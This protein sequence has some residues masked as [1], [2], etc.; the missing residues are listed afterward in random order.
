MEEPLPIE[1]QRNKPIAQQTPKEQAVKE[2]RIR[3]IVQVKDSSPTGTSSIERVIQ[4]IESQDGKQQAAKVMMRNKNIL[5]RSITHLYRLKCNG[6]EQL[7]ELPSKLDLNFNR[8][9]EELKIDELRTERDQ[10]DKAQHRPKRTGAVE[11]G[12]QIIGQTLMEE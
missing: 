8:K 3:D 7:N 10:G 9:G 5:Q 11:A 4:M 1:S 12:N 6:Q 2:P